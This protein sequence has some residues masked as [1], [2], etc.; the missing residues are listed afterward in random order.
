MCQ[1]FQKG[2]SWGIQSCGRP[3]DRSRRHSCDAQ[4]R[5]NSEC[6][7]RT[8]NSMT[9]SQRK[10]KDIWVRGLT[11][12]RHGPALAEAHL[13]RIQ[14]FF[15]KK[16]K[17]KLFIQKKKLFLYTYIYIHIHV[18]MYLYEQTCTLMLKERARL[19][20]AQEN[21]QSACSSSQVFEAG[22]CRTPCPTSQ[23]RQSDGSCACPAGQSFEVNLGRAPC[24]L[25][26]IRQGDGSCACPTGSGL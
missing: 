8:S 17:T 14:L 7:T 18:Y 24:V 9:W 23:V 5:L 4:S 15:P 12:I 3:G 11:Q 10:K 21:C 16:T 20:T 25:G 26:S 1:E 2:G 6:K 13:P 22:S 19:W